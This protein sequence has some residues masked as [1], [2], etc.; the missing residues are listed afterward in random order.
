LKEQERSR[1]YSILGAML[2]IFP[3]II[4]MQ[5]VR[6][7]V[8]SDLKQRVKDHSLSITNPYLTIR[9]ARG[10]IYDRRGNLLAGNRTVYEVGVELQDV[11]NPLTIAQTVS[12]LLGVDYEDALVRASLEPSS[13][14]VYSRLIDNVPP[15]EIEK[16][17][18][19][20]E[21][22][23]ALYAG[24]PDKNAPSLR[25]LVYTPHLGRTYPEESLA[26][27]ILGF[28]NAE[29]DGYFGVE[30]RFSSLLAGQSKTI[31]VPLDPSRAEDLPKVPDGASLVLSID[32]EIQRTMEQILD[33]GVAESGA[34]SGT[35]VVIDPRTGELMAMAMTPRMDLNQF[36]KYAQVF[37][38]DTPFNRAVSQAYEPGSVFKVMTMA[39]AL[40][41]GAV[42]PE[43]VFVDTGVIEVGG[44]LIYNWNG[45]AWGPQDMQGCM[46]HSLNVCLAWVATQLGPEQLYSHLR[47]FGIGHVTGIDLAGEAS[48]RLKEPGDSDWYAADLGTNAFGQ[49]VS[50]TPVQM[51]V[52]VSAVAN[53]GVMMA[54]QIVESVISE[55][56]QHQIDQRILGL[57]IKAE[58]AHTLSEILARSLEKESSDAIVTGYRIAGKTGTAEIP[59]P[60]GYTSNQTNASFVGWGPVDD[61]RFLIY[62]WL[63]KPVSSP[64]GSVVAAPVFRRAAEELVVLLNLPPDSVRHKLERN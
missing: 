43:T 11:R 47:A 37:P 55:G 52:A 17:K 31:R 4:I 21:Q 57:P 25:G 32:R 35:M 2:S 29:G 27:N 18:V 49:G 20:I 58:T 8:N 38:K 41:A 6:I 59:T 61:P 42:T 24:S 1:R 16:L 3:V 56:Y 64:W 12:A 46:Q 15:E 34:T 63:E 40:D 48:G 51:A 39:S 13:S 26:S 9:P 28:V 10:Q 30:E 54:P 19:V 14:A 62:I 45:G 60:Y 36:W 33:G 50:A 53:G 23:N 7:Q 22:M 5:M 44:A